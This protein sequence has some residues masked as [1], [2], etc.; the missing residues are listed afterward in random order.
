MLLPVPSHL[1]TMRVTYQLRRLLGSVHS[2]GSVVFMPDGNSILSAVR[3]R[4][5]WV[6]L[7]EQTSSVMALQ[8]TPNPVQLKIGWELL[9]L[10][11]IHVAAHICCGCDMKGGFKEIWVG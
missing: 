11:G 1:S 3:N 2:N 7:K 8:V 6:D 5:I 10:T 9:W 4:V